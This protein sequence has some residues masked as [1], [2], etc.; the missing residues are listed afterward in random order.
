ME[1]EEKKQEKKST[2]VE[3]VQEHLN[4]KLAIPV[5]VII[6]V[7]AL[8]LF[9]SPIFPYEN[10]Q[11]VT[12]KELYEEM[13][14]VT[15]PDM[16]NPIQTRVCED[17]PARVTIT[18]FKVIG[19]PYGLSGYKCY[20]EFKVTNQEKTEGE[21]EYMVE[22]NVSGKKVV[23]GSIMQTIPPIAPVKYY[24]ESKEGECTAVDKISASYIL[25]SSPTTQECKF[26]TTYPDKTVNR[27]VQ[28]ERDVKKEVTLKG[29]ESLLQKIMGV[30]K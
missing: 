11:I 15:E 7:I 16:E 3:K 9:I 13:T 4:T 17:V 30:N 22:F 27:P 2:H 12:E 21:W 5:F 14:T 24:F 28:K 10:V 23:T 19:K 26:E 6:L 20:A 1:K 25:V 8:I 18:D 29:T